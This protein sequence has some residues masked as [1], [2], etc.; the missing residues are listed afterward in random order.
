MLRA[1]HYQR[2]TD[3]VR[4]L[5]IG[6]ERGVARDIRGAIAYLPEAVDAERAAGLARHGLYRAIPNAVDWAHF[7]EIMRRPFGRLIEVH[8]RAAE[9]G[10]RQINGRFGQ[11]REPVRFGKVADAVGIGQGFSREE[12]PK[13]GEATLKGVA[14]AFNYDRLNP[15]TLERLRLY[16][17]ALI[18]QLETDARDTIEAAIQNVISNGLTADDAVDYIRRVIGLTD[19]QAVAV[20]NYRRGLEAMDSAV[21]TRRLMSGEAM[22]AFTDARARGESLSASMVDALTADYAERYLDYRARTIARTET[23]RAANLG[24]HDVYRQAVE[25]RAIPAEAIT[26]NW[27]IALDERTCPICRSIPE[28]DPDGVGIDELFESDDGP[29]DDPPVHPNCRCSVEYVTNLDLVG[30]LQGVPSGSMVEPVGS[31]RE[32]R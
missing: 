11:R 1:R 30:R 13:E 19:T 14:T 12:T 26:R 25:R 21:L 23:N 29:V 5:A 20:A 16:Q 24:L 10:V 28:N 31:F 2:M 27:K 22:Q 7:R 6:A 8:N 9:L 32:E 15:I 18:Q 17:D 3:P 4:L